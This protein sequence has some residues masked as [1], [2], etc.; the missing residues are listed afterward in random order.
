[1]QSHIP[2]KSCK[3][4]TKEKD[5][6]LNMECKWNAERAAILADDETFLFEDE[7]AARE[8]DKSLLERDY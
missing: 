3:C 8:R 5:C 2:S 7:M 1:M 6:S 4:R